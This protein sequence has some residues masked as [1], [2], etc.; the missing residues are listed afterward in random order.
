MAFA[1]EADELQLSFAAPR[2]RR[3]ARYR[4]RRLFE[5]TRFIFAPQY[6]SSPVA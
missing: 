3:A 6:L 1:A 4:C 5:H 2:V